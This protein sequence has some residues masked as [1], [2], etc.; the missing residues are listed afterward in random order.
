MRDLGLISFVP[1][2]FEV[3]PVRFL[4]LFGFLGSAICGFVSGF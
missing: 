3:L 1:V 2:G 4:S